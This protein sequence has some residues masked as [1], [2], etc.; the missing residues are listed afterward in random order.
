MYQIWF[1]GATNGT[2]TIDLHSKVTPVACSHADE[3]I[4]LGVV[5]GTIGVSVSMP[6]AQKTLPI[7]RVTYA[8]DGGSLL[9]WGTAVML[10]D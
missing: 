9:W 10:L 2:L 5:E 8:T 1:R 7:A 6:P 4:S 3:K